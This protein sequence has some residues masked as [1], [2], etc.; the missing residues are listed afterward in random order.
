MKLASY[1]HEG[2]TGYGAVVGDG[3]VDLSRRI[4]AAY[5]DVKSLLAKAGLA[6]ARKA[7]Q[8]QRLDFALAQARL[9]PP[10]T[11]PGKILC[12]GLNYEGHLKETKREKTED[13]AVFVRFPDGHVGHGQPMVRPRESVK[14]DYEGEIAVVIGKPGRRIAEKDAWDHVGGY[15]CYNDGSVRD[16]QLAT[17]Q[18]TAGKN[19][20]SSGAFGP[21]IVTA[22]EIAP[23]ATLTLITRLNGAEMPRGTSNMLIHSIPRL[24]AHI[25]AWTALAAGDVIS[26][27]TPGGVGMRRDPPV[28]MKPGD[29]VE[30]EVDRVGVLRNP[31]VQ[32]E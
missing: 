8:G 22:D 32:E 26:T 21:W 20:P 10:V 15:S 11:N 14:Y 6:E 19:F 3:I 29:V 5:P 18:W 1:V 24:L 7:I 4:G 9:L 30:V 16:W 23:G 25:S 17:T 31:I 2:V 13:P 12:I 27:G 28:F